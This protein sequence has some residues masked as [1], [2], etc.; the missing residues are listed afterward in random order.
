M[1][2]DNRLALQQGWCG[3]K[4]LIFSWAASLQV[5]LPRAQVVQAG[6]GA[7]SARSTSSGMAL[8]RGAGLAHLVSQCF[9]VLRTWRLSSSS[10]LLSCPSC[11]NTTPSCCSRQRSG[12][13]GDEAAAA[14][15]LSRRRRAAR[16]RRTA[17]VAGGSVGVGGRAGAGQDMPGCEEGQSRPGEGAAGESCW[18]R[19]RLPS[20]ASSRE[21]GRQDCHGTHPQP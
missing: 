9:P 14:A 2:C 18:L 5:R 7:P 19:C 17:R 20:L 3:N 11:R 13:T 16:C 12:A 4:G 10:L 8:C 1:P 21:T 15:S 6:T